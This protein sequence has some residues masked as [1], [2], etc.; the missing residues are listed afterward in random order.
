M[1][2]LLPRR[3][4]LAFVV[5]PVSVAIALTGCSSSSV[6][7]GSA[8]TPAPTSSAGAFA[9][10]IPKGDIVAY[11][12]TL[13]ANDLAA[14]TGFTPKSTGPTAQ[15]PGATI[16]YVAADGTNGGITT[17][18]SG[19]KEAAAK[20]GW[21]VDVFDGLATAAGNTN[22]IN[23]AIASKPAA[24]ILG[25]VDPTQ[26]ASAI[27]TAK[28]AGIPVIGWHAGTTAGPGNGLFSNVT[29]DPLAVSQIAAAYAVANSNG[30]ARAVIFTDS[31]YAIAVEKA[32]A[33]QAYISACSG[34]KVL[35][36]QDSPIATASTRMPGIVSQL[37]QNDGS[38]FYMLAINGAYFDGSAPALRSAKQNPAGPPYEIAAGDGSASELQRIRTAQYQTA[39]VADP[40]VLEG[41]DAVDEVNRALAKTSWSGF[42]PAPGLITKANVPAGTTFDPNSGYRTLY[43]KVWG[44]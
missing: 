44:K 5:I 6:G 11:S 12:K 9:S 17:V 41:W 14:T 40:L 37:L 39:T 1:K 43:A 31:E 26:E 7:G 3:A 8:S 10:I 36:Y 20:I 29:T 22:A 23:Q 2:K 25:G 34:C 16:A 19:V 24:I 42:V 38:D 32:K 4:G 21:K 27:A 33:M 30:K 18:E 15:D 28:T 35:S 13:V